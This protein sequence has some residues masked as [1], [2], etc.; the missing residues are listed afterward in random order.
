MELLHSVIA[1]IPAACSFSALSDDGILVH[2]NF[3]YK[4]LPAANPPRPSAS[5][6]RRERTHAKSA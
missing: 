4:V 3:I 1:A 2:S 6:F 5:T